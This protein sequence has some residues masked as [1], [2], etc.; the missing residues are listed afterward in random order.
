MKLNNLFANA[1]SKALALAAAVMMM[2]MTFT[3]C[4]SDNDDEQKFTNTVTLDGE[5]IKI[6]KLEM[7]K[8]GEV[9]WLIMKLET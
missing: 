9:Y 2:G 7:N 3:A 1:A 4:S 8:I 5:V 6:E